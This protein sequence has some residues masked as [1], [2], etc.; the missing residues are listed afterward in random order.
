MLKTI[1]PALHFRRRGLLDLPSWLIC[2]Q[3][4]ELAIVLSMDDNLHPDRPARQVAPPT[5][6][7]L[8]TM[9][10]IAGPTAAL[11]LLVIGLNAGKLGELLLAVVGLFVGVALVYATVGA[12][13]LGLYFFCVVL[14][15]LVALVLQELLNWPVRLLVASVV[16]AF[17]LQ[18]VVR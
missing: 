13:A 14:L 4:A 2:A 10:T 8:D 6:R 16:L 11:L 1:T 5:G 9:L 12:E 15:R 18:V 7:L 17:V 3:I